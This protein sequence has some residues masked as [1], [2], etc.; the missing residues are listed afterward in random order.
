MSTTLSNL[1]QQSNAGSDQFGFK[2]KKNDLTDLH[3]QADA[4]TCRTED[5]M[6]S[7]AEKGLI[8]R[9]GCASDQSE[10]SA[11]PARWEDRSGGYFY[12][13]CYYDF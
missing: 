11:S 5:E 13:Y 7:E 12:C 4:K 10:K 9:R 3:T 6:N 2:K 1:R 8:K